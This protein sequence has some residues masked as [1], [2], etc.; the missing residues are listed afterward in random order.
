MKYQKLGDLSTFS[1][2]FPQFFAGDSAC[3]LGPTEA[4][5]GVREEQGTDPSRWGSSGQREP[6]WGG[7]RARCRT[8]RWGS[9]GWGDAA[10]EII[11]NHPTPNQALVL[12]PSSCNELQVLPGWPGIPLCHLAFNERAISH[13]SPYQRVA[14]PHLCLLPNGQ[15]DFS[16]FLVWIDWKSFNFLSSAPLLINIL[17]LNHL[18]LLKLYYKQSGRTRPLSVNTMPRDFLS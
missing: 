5:P 1:V 14:W 15:P 6:A 13:S 10:F 16:F 8:S 11:L 7:W 12:T 18:P 2:Y 9:T 3:C 4:T 17:S